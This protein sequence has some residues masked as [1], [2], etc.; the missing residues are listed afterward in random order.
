MNFL[1]LFDM[2]QKLDTK[3]ETQHKLENESLIERKILA[4][5]VEVGELANETRCFK[6]WSLKAPAP[7]DVI[8][9]EY[10]DGIHFILSLGLEINV[11]PSLKLEEIHAERSVTEQFLSVY[12]TITVFKEQQTLQVYKKMFEEYLCLGHLLGFTKEQ[13]EHAYVSKNE[14]NHERQKQGY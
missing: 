3:I 14:V 6:F 7:I 10:V 5:L 2:Q 13:I 9:E 1:S 8:L 12:Q 11:D 4:L